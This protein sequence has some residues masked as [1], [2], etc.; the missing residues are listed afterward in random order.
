M[1]TTEDATQ[2]AEWTMGLARARELLIEEA[3]QSMPSGGAVQR[4]E[5]LD[6][7]DDVLMGLVQQQP[8]HAW[9]ALSGLENG[10]SDV[11]GISER[12]AQHLK[13]LSAQPAPASKQKDSA[14]AYARLASIFEGQIKLSQGKATLDWVLD[15][16]RALGQTPAELD[17][18]L[19]SMMVFMNRVARQPEIPSL[20]DAASTE[21]LSPR[22]QGNLRMMQKYVAEASAT[23]ASF[24][25]KL[26]LASSRSGEAW[27][28]AKD[29]GDFSLWLPHLETLLGLL[30][31]N[32]TLLN[33][34]KGSSGSLYEALMDFSTTNNGLSEAGVRAVLD[35]LNT[36]LPELITRIQA[37]QAEE[38]ARLGSP[39]PLPDVSE[40]VKE[41]VAAR[42]VKAMGLPPEHSRIDTCPH[43]FCAGEWDDIR[44]TRFTGRDLAAVISDMFHEAGH[45][46]YS[47][48]L[49][50]DMKYQPGGLYQSLWI[51]E[52]QSTFWDR[53]IG[54]G[55]PFM[56]FLSNLL[57]EEL[58][59]GT[60]DPASI[61]PENL[62]RLLNRVT[63]SF[64]RTQA[65]E[66]TYHA[67]I[68]LRDT[69]ERDMLEGRL[70]PKDLPE[71][72]N[73][74]MKE[75]LGITPSSDKEGCLQDVH[76][77]TGK[78]W[79]YFPAYTMGEVAAAQL[80]ATLR[81]EHP[82]VDEWIENG[83]FAPIAQWLREKVHHHGALMEG[84]TIIQEATGKRLSPDDWLRYVEGKYLEGRER[85]PG[86]R[87]ESVS[88]EHPQPATKGLA[89]GT[90]R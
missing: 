74:K 10:Q 32:A 86:S 73:R 67:H 29:S 69:L 42:L 17:S 16:D 14:G 4:Q 85:A 53:Q 68:V 27:K 52:S 71:A 81:K 24:D 83:H 9:E 20:L 88:A 25:A 13:K 18:A 58:P 65:D 30:R 46:L 12:A 43:A 8:F 34:A 84:E 61:A 35:P 90:D 63:P 57:K 19:S 47:H 7:L 26:T 77:S 1:G 49:P 64:I 11:S 55:K 50:R 2:L 87:V 36:K 79:G 21:S 38:D 33:K 70:A 72:F 48:Q 76:W 15:A 51:H 45:G 28:N 54:H 82:N 6:A 78:Y 66:V 41:R 89:Q 75:L 56:K 80:M 40:D 23:E 44:L 37:V 31:E 59:L 60:Y 3:K 39:V 5:I 62:Y 22:E